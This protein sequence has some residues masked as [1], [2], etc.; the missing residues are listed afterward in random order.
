MSN[1]GLGGPSARK[2]GLYLNGVPALLAD[3]CISTAFRQD[4]TVSDAPQE[5]NAFQSYDKVQ[6]P[7]DARIR[8]AQ[9]GS[10]LDRQL[11]FV[12]LI[13]IAGSYDLYSVVTPEISY[14]NM[15]ITH[16]EYERKSQNGVSLIVAEL[17]LTQIRQTA[18]ATYSN[19][20]SPAAAN[21][22]NTG[23]QQTVPL[24]SAQTT[25]VEASPDLVGPPQF[26]GS[27]IF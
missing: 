17:W 6:V 21:P 13:A 11:F 8:M 2:W 24:T 20:K 7:F 25:A 4:Y 19:V 16:Y 12:T 14:T 22:V 23:T 27:I 5:P 1:I 9:G 3:S 15:N 26:G 18:S 10:D